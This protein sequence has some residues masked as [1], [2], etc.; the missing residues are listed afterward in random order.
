MENF[1]NVE[2]RAGEIYEVEVGNCRE[3]Y[4]GMDI[5]VAGLH[6]PR[7]GVL[8]GVTTRCP[9]VPGYFVTEEVFRRDS[10]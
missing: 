4:H 1:D 3:D 10:S 6:I 5:Y 9:L 7:L 2:A 8:R